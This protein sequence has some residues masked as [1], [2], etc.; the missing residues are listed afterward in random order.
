[1][2]PRN[3]PFDLPTSSQRKVCQLMGSA[4]RRVRTN[5]NYWLAGNFPG[6]SGNKSVGE[7]EK[8]PA[9]DK[10]KSP[11]DSRAFP[12]P[13]GIRMSLGRCGKAPG[14]FAEMVE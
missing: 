6:N 4:S 3:P 10:A 1:M 11:P 2:L 12:E 5:L 9:G 14:T 13:N 8:L 7:G